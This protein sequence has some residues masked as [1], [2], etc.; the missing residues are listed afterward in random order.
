[1]I[2][3]A[4]AAALFS[5]SKGNS[6]YIG[7]PSEGVLIDA[8]K[9]CKQIELAME[10]NGLKMSNV[11][12]VFITHEHSDHCS[13]LKILSKKYG[14]DIYASAGTLNALERSDKISPAGKVN[15][16]ESQ[17][18]IGNMLVERIN[19]PHDAAESCC[20]RVVTADG[21]SAL[22][23]TDMGVIT[24]E[25]H[26]AAV[27][28]DFVVLESNHD[29]DMLKNGIYPFV[30]KQRI[31]SSKGHLS[32]SDC[33]NELVNLVNGGTLRLMLGHLS[34]QNNTPS[35]AMS[36]AV[37]ALEQAG[38]KYKTDFTLDIAK[39]EI[40]ANTIIF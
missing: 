20:Y 2:G 16:I 36:T 5:G 8:G 14:F 1:M 6:Y 25:V 7:T 18:A 30:L 4:R 12:A 9:S 17:I 32:N 24:K 39:P 33:S 37:A 28:S 38:M 22:V 13:A 19:T 21:K 31:L 26:N 10:A 23:A 35:I 3:L 40:F 34:E 15:V 29:I 27:S 11:S